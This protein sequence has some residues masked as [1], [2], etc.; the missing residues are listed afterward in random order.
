MK[1]NNIFNKINN[2]EVGGF[3]AKENLPLQQIWIEARLSQIKKQ[4]LP[5]KFKSVVK[6]LVRIK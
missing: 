4:L 2:L 1:H 3:I 5:K 6:H